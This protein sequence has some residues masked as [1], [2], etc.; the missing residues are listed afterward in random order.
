MSRIL[1]LSH[2]EDVDGI[3]SAALIKAAFK[4]SSVILVDYANLIKVLET[5]LNEMGNSQ[6]AFNHIFLCD[7][8]LSKKNE[9]IFINIIK[10]IMSYGCKVTYIDHHD[11]GLET[12]SEL[13]GIGVKLVH[14][15][16]E[17]TS[18]Q[19]YHKYKKKLKP[20]AAFLAAAGAITDYMETKPKASTIVSKYDRQFLMLEASALSYMISSGQHETE[21]LSTIIDKLSDMKYPHDVDGGFN[22]AEKY[23]QKV[24]NAVKSIENCISIGNNFAYLE[25][26]AELSSSLIVNFVLGLSEKTVALVYRFKADI[27]S[28]IISVRGSKDCMVHLGRA[29]NAISSDLGGSGGGHDRAC[30]AVIPKERMK[31]FLEKLDAVISNNKK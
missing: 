14:N 10:N 21:F 22:R 2:K 17:C 18:V 19:I 25:S 27:N 9:T 8:G 3:S 23:A 15:V 28:Y 16:E 11:L 4:V 12:K 6:S 31:T 26:N 30:G 29:V 1:C 24:S 20:H 7:L 13:K 5:V